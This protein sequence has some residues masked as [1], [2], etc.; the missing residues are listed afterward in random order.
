MDGVTEA[1]N[2]FEQEFGEDRLID[3]LRR[4]RSLPAQELALSVVEEVQ[5]FSAKK[6]HDDITL[7]VAKGK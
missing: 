2:D 7:I 4:K 1:F 5:S 6:Q 3:V